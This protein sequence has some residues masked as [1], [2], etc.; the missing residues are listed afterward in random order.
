[1]GIE[2]VVIEDAERLEIK[3]KDALRTANALRSPVALLFGGEF[4]L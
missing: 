4:T 2:H 3:I 1:L